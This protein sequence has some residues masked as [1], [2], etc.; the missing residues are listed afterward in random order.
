[1]KMDFYSD[2]YFNMLREIVN[3]LKIRGT[4]PIDVKGLIMLNKA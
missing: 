3:G 2:M 1:M 4:I